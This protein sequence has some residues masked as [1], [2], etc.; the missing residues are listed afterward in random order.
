MGILIV[1]G[2]ILFVLFFMV[3]FRGA[4]YVPTHTKSVE[5]ALDLLHLSKGDT[6]VDLGSGDGIVLKL[7]AKRGYRVYGYE[8][9]PIL[10]AIAWLRCW[11]YRKLV[12]IKCRDFWLTKLPPET[13]AVFIFLAGPFL[14]KIDKKLRDTVATHPKSIKVASYGFRLPHVEMLVASDEGVQ[15]YLYKKA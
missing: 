1:L 12:T 6:L 2:I 14:K 4:P 8:I 13:D 7:A 3:A 9:N 11:K 15:V 10:C 5:K